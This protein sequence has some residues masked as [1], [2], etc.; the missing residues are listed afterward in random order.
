MHMREACA[1]KLQLGM[2]EVC[3]D[4]RNLNDGDKTGTKAP[5]F[6]DYNFTI[7]ETECLYK[8]IIVI[9]SMPNNLKCLP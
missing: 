6:R 9:G 7:K 8:S 4:G 5:G 2:P 3:G 1:H